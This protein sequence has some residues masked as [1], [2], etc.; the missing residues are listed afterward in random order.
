MRDDQRAGI[1][2]IVAF[3]LAFPFGIA[4]S[5]MIPPAVA[6]MALVAFPVDSAFWR[7]R[8]IPWDLVL[9]GAFLLWAALSFLWSPHDNPGQ[10]WRTGLGVP[11][12]ILFALRIGRLEG[13]WKR[14][15]ETAMMFAVL[16]LGL[17]LLAEAVLDGTATRG[18]KLAEE[19]FDGMALRD[20]NTHVNR[21]LGHAAA[22]LIMLAVPVALIAWREGGPLVGAVVIALAAVAAFSFDTE[23][24]TA[25]FI[26]ASIAAT[27][28]LFWPRTLVALVFG[29]V[30]GALIVMPLAL[31][32]FIAQLPQGVRD[33]MPLSWVWRLEIWA[34]VSELIREKPWF[35]YGLDA[36]RPLNAEMVLHGFVVERLPHHP[37]NA[38]LHVWLETGA[39]GALLLAAGLVALGGRIAG[40]PKLSRLQAVAVVWVLMVYVSLIVF[41][42]GVWQEWHQGTVALATTSVLFLGAKRPGWR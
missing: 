17:F 38:T 13:R 31:P 33:A 15:V 23:V 6:L 27:L 41:S 39:V 3:A 19:N 37:H 24:N 8:Q 7:M 28:T 18:F 22:P 11:L 2:A 14:R 25:A 40:S 21:N 10:V 35:G 42:Y 9:A 32:D 16:A 12:Y 4:G 36:S 26:L 20:V 5:L 30:A 1:A 34:Y 29:C